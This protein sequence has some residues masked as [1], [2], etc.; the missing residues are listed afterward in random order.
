M[1][2]LRKI[3]IENISNFNIDNTVIIKR[4]PE[5]TEEKSLTEVLDVF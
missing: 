3:F 4:K 1:E 5:L 2:R